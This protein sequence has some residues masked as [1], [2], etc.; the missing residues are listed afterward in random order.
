MTEHTAYR[1]G[2]RSATRDAL[3]GVDIERGGAAMREESQAIRR[4]W[5]IVDRDAAAWD[6]GYIRTARRLARI[7]G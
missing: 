2:S 6:A 7:G 1:M 4:T 3:A 5:G